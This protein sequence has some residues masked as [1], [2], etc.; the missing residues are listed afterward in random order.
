M[1]SWI[2]VEVYVSNHTNAE[3]THG[4]C[5]DCREALYPEYYGKHRT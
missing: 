5:P 4:I 2:P 3:F 1:S